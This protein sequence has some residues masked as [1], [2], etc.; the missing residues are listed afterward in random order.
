MSPGFAVSSTT[1]EPS[2]GSLRPSAPHPPPPPRSLPPSGTSGPAPS[3]PHPLATLA[4]SR[5]A[6]RDGAPPARAR[7]KARGVGGV[8]CPSRRPAG[9]PRD[10]VAGDR[11]RARRR[12]WA[13]AQR[14]RRLKRESGGVSCQARPAPRWARVDPQIPPQHPAVFFRRW[15]ANGGLSTVGCRRPYVA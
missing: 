8:G 4:P 12:G 5:S 2:K 11:R 13:L 3:P 10:Q 7:T 15:A 1:W 14:R 9:S 6:S